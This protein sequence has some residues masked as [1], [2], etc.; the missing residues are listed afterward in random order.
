MVD[1]RAAMEMVPKE[2]RSEQIGIVS[3]TSAQIMIRALGQGFHANDGEL[4]PLR[5]REWNSL[6]NA[7]AGHPVLNKNLEYVSNL[8][9]KCMQLYEPSGARPSLESKE[10][11]HITDTFSHEILSSLIIGMYRSIQPNISSFASITPE[12]LQEIQRRY[13]RALEALFKNAP[14]GSNRGR[15]FEKLTTARLVS[16]ILLKPDI[17]LGG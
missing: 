10:L 9:E 14:A 3:E 12:Q 1:R 15:Y 16:Q 6:R 4:R 5:Q 11:N 2:P 7:N 13:D 17:L 8:F